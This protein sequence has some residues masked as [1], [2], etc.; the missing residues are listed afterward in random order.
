MLESRSRTRWR[1]GLATLAALVA[2]AAAPAVLAS[3]A[4]TR[5]VGQSIV[6]YLA[7]DRSSAVLLPAPGVSKQTYS[8]SPHLQALAIRLCPPSSTDPPAASS[9][10]SPTGTR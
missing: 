3:P 1:A 7:P 8:V 10:P 5:T 9:I 6:L 2:V 4:T